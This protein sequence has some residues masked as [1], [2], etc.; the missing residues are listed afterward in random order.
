MPANIFLIHHMK[1]S[2]GHAVI[3]WLVENAPGA[4][5]VNNEIPIQPIL[6]EQR[7]V[8]DGSMPY[9]VWLRAK[10][11]RLAG[12]IAEASTLFV[13]LEDHELTVRPFSHPDTKLVIVLRHPESLF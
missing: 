6:L 8:P 11:L 12:K 7:S 2:G 9:D 10:R 4:V 5:F 3:N 1:R 13:S